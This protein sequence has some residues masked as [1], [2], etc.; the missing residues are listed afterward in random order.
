MQA[1][2]IERY[3][4]NSRFRVFARFTI[5]IVAGILSWVALA[6][7]I[8]LRPSEY[9]LNIGDVTN[10]D[11]LAPRTLTF[12]SDILTQKARQEAE[13]RV[14]PVY[15]PV[16]LE[17]SKNQL[18]QLEMNLALINAIRL[19]SSST[20]EEKVTALT[21]IT[22]YGFDEAG[23]LNILAMSQT[24]WDGISNEAVALFERVMGGTVREDMVSDYIAN[25]P[26]LV[27]LSF[28]KDQN[29]LIARLVTPHIRANSLYSEQQTT[30][31]RQEASD[32]VKPVNRTFIT[33]QVI[34]YRGGIVDELSYEALQNYGLVKTSRKNEELISSGLIVFLMAGFIALYH[35]LKKLPPVDDL[36][37]LIIV[38]TLF[39][40][41]LYSARFLIPNR[42][43]LPYI[44]PIAAFGLTVAALYRIETAMIY[45]LPLAILSTYNQYS[46]SIIILYILGTFC[47]ILVLG[48]PRKVIQFVWAGLAVTVTSILVILAYKLPD[49]TSD[50]LGI[51]TLI[52]ASMF[53]GI[54][55]ASITLLLQYV[56]AQSLGLTTPLMLNELMRPDSR[57]LQFLLREAPGTY[58]HSLQVANLAE[59]AAEKIGADAALTRVGALYHDVGK[60]LN[61]QFFIENQ[62][63]GQIDIHDSLDPVVTASTIIQ[64]IPDGIK[65]AHKHHLPTRLQAFI[66]EHHGT[67]RAG[68]QYKR[69]LEAA[70]NNPEQVDEELFRYPGSIPQSRE[71]ALLML[72]DSCE[73]RARAELP[74]DEPTLRT[75]IRKVIQ[76]AMDEEQLVNTSLTLRDLDCITDSF[77]NNLMGVYHPRVVYPTEKDKTVR[78]ITKPGSTHKTIRPKKQ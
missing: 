28:T 72:A 76:R 29:S 78:V 44:F 57:L 33:G 22:V 1:S 5:L 62:V 54:A 63:Q 16:D 42:A 34:L 8:E 65:L 27:G 39:L 50:W 10:Q 61:P 38:A 7:P 18:A 20:Q 17:I 58:Q 37:S 36:R 6:V 48:K 77:T 68:Y 74:K 64:H 40:I 24:T 19:N 73:A 13:L 35:R 15:L 70:G 25:I 43:V 41:F 46:P 75:L 4:K 56:F 14:I 59:Q 53:N 2:Y 55:S 12:T 26:T 71:T 23:A 52:G 30:L 49:P 60:A 47:G 45:C 9:T 31:R 21:N 51:A 66:T 32:A 3:Q 11:I 69:A 67:L